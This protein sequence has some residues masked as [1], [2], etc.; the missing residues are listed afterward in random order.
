MSVCEGEVGIEGRKYLGFLA[1]KFAKV[2]LMVKNCVP[3]L[4]DW[5]FFYRRN[6]TI[7][8]FR[9]ETMYYP[10]HGEW[11]NIRTNPVCILGTWC[12]SFVRLVVISCHLLFPCFHSPFSLPY[13]PPSFFFLSLFLSPPSSSPS[14]SSSLSSSPSLS[15]CASL[16]SFPFSLFLPSVF[17]PF[18]LFYPLSCSSLSFPCLSYSCTRSICVFWQSC[19]WTIK[20]STMTQTLSCFTL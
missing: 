9:I 17:F 7:S 8:S 14:L 1:A 12:Y 15:S 4:Y 2:Q 10:M 3:A 13:L 18:S 19:S 5:R 16:P 6:L 11:C 20:L